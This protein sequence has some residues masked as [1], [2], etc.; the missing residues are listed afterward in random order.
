MTRIIL[1]TGPIVAF[2]N[3]RDRY[4]TWANEVFKL[5]KPPVYTC[6]AVISEACFLLRNMEG[7]SIAV[8][9]LLERNLVVVDFDLSGEIKAVKKLMSKYANVPMSLADACLIR[10]SEMEKNSQIIT[11]DRDFNVYRRFDRQQV[12]VLMP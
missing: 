8:V 1:D 9:E 2:L 11:L 5:F 7:G 10:M 4:F 3:K 6:D 12:P